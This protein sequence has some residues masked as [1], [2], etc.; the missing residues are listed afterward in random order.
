MSNAQTHEHTQSPAPRLSYSINTAADDTGL[1][2]SR[3]YKLINDG[4]LQTFK[5]GS[6]TMIHG[7]ALAALVDR[8]AA[9]GTT[10]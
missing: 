1:S 7:A 10:E 4:Q 5:V 6:R 8:F 2:R 3:I 9:S